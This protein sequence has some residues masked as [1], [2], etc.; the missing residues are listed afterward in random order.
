M[1]SSRHGMTITRRLT[2]A[3]ALHS[4]TKSGC[5]SSRKAKPAKI[6]ASSMRDVSSRLTLTEELL[7]SKVAGGGAFSSEG[8][9]TG[10]FPRLQWTDSL[11][12]TY[13]HMGKH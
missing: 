6:P 4:L 13:V 12:C 7:A 1:L 11:L 2:A 8:V 9:A 3:V 10:R 5:G